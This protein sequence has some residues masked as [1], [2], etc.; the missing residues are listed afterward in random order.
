MKSS[1]NYIIN[2]LAAGFLSL[3][4]VSVPLFW[5][6]K[7][8]QGMLYAVEWHYQKSVEVRPSGFLPEID[9]E[10]NTVS[11]SAVATYF[12]DEII[13]A[14]LGLLQDI[15]P[16]RSELYKTAY[17][18]A[19]R[20]PNEKS[21]RSRHLVYFDKN[22]GLVVHCNLAK[23]GRAGKSRWRKSGYLYAGPEGVADT[24]EKTL[25]RFAGPLI[26]QRGNTGEFGPCP[27]LIF[28]GKVRRFFKIQFDRASVIKGP[29]LDKDCH[30]VQISLLDKNREF[31]GGIRWQQPYRRATAQEQEEWEKEQGRMETYD[32]ELSYSRYRPIHR[33]GP[34]NVNIGPD[35]KAYGQSEDILVLDKSCRIRRL[36]AKTLEFVGSAGSLPVSPPRFHTVTTD[37]LLAY[38]VVP[39]F[40]DGRELGIACSSV[41]SDASALAVSVFDP[42]GKPLG[43][44]AK[45]RNPLDSP[46][47][48]GLIVAKFLLENLH[49][50]VLALASYFTRSS[51]EPSAGHRALFI[52]PNALAPTAA[53]NNYADNIGM[54]I[55]IELMMISPSI[56]L[57]L[58]LTWHI[59]TNAAAVGLSQRAKFYWTIGTIAFGLPAYITY[60]LT[61]SKIKLVTCASCGKPRRPDMEKCH[62][63]GSKWHAPELTPPAWRVIADKS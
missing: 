10:P 33:R 45:V 48:P 4:F 42:N 55:W 31:C 49:P 17:Y 59:R 21:I 11:H 63:C 32:Y 44:N 24:A 38:R 41:S 6:G 14:G 7:L 18:Y 46:G 62:R 37:G 36:D 28:D 8:C 54:R 50:P 40:A 2:V 12:M 19:I 51:F 5:A 13:L 20:D 25:G 53:R 29:E 1:S 35:V 57:A 58:L 56:I 43:S 61:L 15:D 30:P 23:T 27:V 9:S 60:R 26:L 34:P 52:L 47:G 3:L 16:L 22:L 39:F